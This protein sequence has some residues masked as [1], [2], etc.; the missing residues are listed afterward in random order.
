[1][2]NIY[3]TTLRQSRQYQIF[4]NSFSLL[5]F[6][7]LNKKHSHKRKWN[8]QQIILTYI[9]IFHQ[10][11][12]IKFKFCLDENAS[13]IFSLFLSSHIC[14]HFNGFSVRCLNI[15]ILILLIPPLSIKVNS[16]SAFGN[17]FTFLTFSFHVH[18]TK[19]FLGKEKCLIFLFSFSPWKCSTVM[20]PKSTFEKF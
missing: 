18:F 15:K 3:A 4:N 14:L 6:I 13:A 20:T 7:W 9:T 10:N 8:K 16:I 5:M 2:G 1:M 11:I 17:L 19:S 12:F